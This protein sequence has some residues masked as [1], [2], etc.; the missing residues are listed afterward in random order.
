MVY[1]TNLNDLPEGDE[2][3]EV[4]HNFS[5]ILRRCKEKVYFMNIQFRTE[6]VVETMDDKTYDDMSIQPVRPLRS[7]FCF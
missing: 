1:K 2:Q 6:H 7:T 4:Y 3:Y 5:R